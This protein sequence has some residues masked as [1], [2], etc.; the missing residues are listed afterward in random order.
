MEILEVVQM[1]M[2]KEESPP[3]FQILVEM[4]R[5]MRAPLWCDDMSAQEAASGVDKRPEFRSVVIL[6]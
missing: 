3:S 1:K 5:Q 4:D 2:A 6:I